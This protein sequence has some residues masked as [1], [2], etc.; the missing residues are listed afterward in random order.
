M[1][2]FKRHPSVIKVVYLTHV[3][4][5]QWFLEISVNASSSQHTDW[6]RAGR[7]GDTLLR[8]VYFTVYLPYFFFMLLLVSHT[9]ISLIDVYKG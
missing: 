3:S 8:T 6:T 9:A 7:R 4:E 5:C 1:E 2:L